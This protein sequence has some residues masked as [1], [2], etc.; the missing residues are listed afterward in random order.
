MM[1]CYTKQR[2]ALKR[3]ATHCNALQ[4]TA[5]TGVRVVT[6]SG[7]GKVAILNVTS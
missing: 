7:D 5:T 4:H 3:A 2:A 6:A 1:H